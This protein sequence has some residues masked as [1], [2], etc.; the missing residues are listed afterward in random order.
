MLGPFETIGNFANGS[1]FSCT[2]PLR[3]HRQSVTPICWAN[4]SSWQNLGMSI[5]GLC[6]VLAQCPCICLVGPYD[7]FGNSLR[8]VPA[9]CGPMRLIR[10]AAVLPVVLMKWAYTNP[11][12][13][14]Y[15]DNRWAHAIL[16]T[17]YHCGPIPIYAHILIMGP[18]GLFRR[19]RQ[20]VTWVLPTT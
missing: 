9:H 5:L 20:I 10:S 17:I 19:T 14:N 18:H 13:R 12:S 3:F 2:G 8:M 11:S 6:E 4:T 16:C 15:T 7:W 1:R